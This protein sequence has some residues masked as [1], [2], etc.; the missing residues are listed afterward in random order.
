MKR[1]IKSHGLQD[2]AG[3]II[4]VD[5][6]RWGRETY[7]EVTYKPIGQPD[8]VGGTYDTAAEAIADLV[9]SPFGVHLI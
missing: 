5:E 9:A 3:N 1:I 7:A 4:R 6:I 8:I 2:A